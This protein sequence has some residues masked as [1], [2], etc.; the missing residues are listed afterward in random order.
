[1]SDRFTLICAEC[2]AEYPDPYALPVRDV[3]GAMCVSCGCG[4]DLALIEFE[5]PAWARTVPCWV[6][7]GSETVSPVG[8]NK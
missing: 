1:M 7:T 8:R 6:S 5:P 3:G 2:D 4:R